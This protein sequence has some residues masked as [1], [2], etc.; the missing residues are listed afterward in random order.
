MMFFYSLMCFMAV[1]FAAITA[2]IAKSYADTRFA[3]VMFIVWCVANV[4]FAVVF[5][6][7][8]GGRWPA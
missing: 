5:G 4:L 1:I 2:W 8:A 3:R 6:L 7:M